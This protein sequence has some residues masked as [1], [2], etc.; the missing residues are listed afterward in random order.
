VEDG[1]LVINNVQRSHVGSYLCSVFTGYG[2]FRAVS[3]LRIKGIN[4]IL[5]CFADR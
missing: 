5:F 1:A 2:I 4:L 3:T